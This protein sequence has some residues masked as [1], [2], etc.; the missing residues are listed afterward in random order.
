LGGAL[1]KDAKAEICFKPEKALL[2]FNRNYLK[3]ETYLYVMKASQSLK[4]YR[5]FRRSGQA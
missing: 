3:S 4:S 1:T 5:A 2:K